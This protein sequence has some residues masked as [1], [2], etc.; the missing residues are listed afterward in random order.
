M[1]LTALPAEL[2][3]QIL[4][5]FGSKELRALSVAS[6]CLCDL[7][8]KHEEIWKGV[9]RHQWNTLNFYIGPTDAMVLSSHLQQHASDAYRFLCQAVQQVPSHLDLKYD[10]AYDEDDPNDYKMALVPHSQ[11]LPQF[12]LDTSN[13][14]TSSYG[15]S[16]R[17]NAPYRFIPT[18]VVHRQQ[19]SH[20]L[21]W[22]VDLTSSMYFEMTIGTSSSTPQRDNPWDQNNS[23]D[24]VSIGLAPRRYVV[25]E[26]HPGASLYQWFV[27]YHLLEGWESFSYGYHGEEG[28]FMTEPEVEDLETFGPGDTIGCGLQYRTRQAWVYFTKNGRRL[29]GE[30]SCCRGAALYPMFGVNIDV[31]ITVNF[32]QQPFQFNAYDEM[33]TPLE[34]QAAHSS[35][36]RDL[37]LDWDGYL[38]AEID[39]DDAS[40]DSSEL[41][42]DSEGNFY[43]D[44]YD[45]SDEEIVA[46]IQ[47]LQ[48]PNMHHL[49]IHGIRP[50]VIRAIMQDIPSE[51]AMQRE[52]SAGDEDD[53]PDLVSD[54][55]EESAHYSWQYAVPNVVD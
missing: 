3:L 8:K 24:I 40:S 44:E 20:G 18:V 4:Q 2:L 14:S 34:F 27:A 17:A 28:V 13:L 7:I 50:D 54:S 52:L 10:R 42:L 15:R 5:N 41:F 6:R 33:V 45:N 11:A 39:D 47:Q 51:E 26:N 12:R 30:F 9:F 32:G 55:D 49:F 1:G 38:Y 36:H 25:I 48:V 22:Q 16:I 29:D 43:D 46:F 31:P 21:E 35:I 19:R 37:F 53:L 23:W